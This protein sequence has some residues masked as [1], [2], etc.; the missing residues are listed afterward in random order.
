MCWNFHWNA[1]GANCAKE[2][3]KECDGNV[4]GMW[5]G[6]WGWGTITMECISAGGMWKECTRNVVGMY[7]WPGNVKGI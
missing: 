4:I 1:P 6:L 5:F 7:L 2:M 3:R